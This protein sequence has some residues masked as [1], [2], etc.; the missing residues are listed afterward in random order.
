MGGERE[1]EREREG[2]RGF[3][4]THLFEI[5]NT[6]DDRSLSIYIYFFLSILSSLCNV[7]F[8]DHLCFTFFDYSLYLLILLLPPSTSFFF[9]YH[10]LF[11]SPSL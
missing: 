1:R 7:V 8:I 2:D 10:A 4:Y 5:V 3:V 9:P 6:P 11:L